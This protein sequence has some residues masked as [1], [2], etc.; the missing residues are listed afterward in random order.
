MIREF[1]TE[2]AESVCAVLNACWRP[3]SQI[4]ISPEGFR[5]V[6][7]SSPEWRNTHAFVGV[8]QE[9][10]NGFAAVVTAGNC[11][12]VAFLHVHPAS[13]GQGIGHGLLR[14]IE[15]TAAEHGCPVLS[16]GG[17]A[18]HSP[19]HGAKAGDADTDSFLRHRGCQPRFRQ[20]TRVLQLPTAIL[21]GR[22]SGYDRRGYD[23]QIVEAADVDYPAARRGVVALCHQCEAP[24][25]A[26][27]SCYVGAQVDKSNTYFAAAFHG[28]SLVGFVG[29]VPFRGVG[30]GYEA[31][32]Q[33]GPILV[34]PRHRNQGI[35]R[36]LLLTSLAA[37][38]DLGCDRA[39]L[40]GV[41][42]GPA[43]HLY[44]SIGFQTVVEWV[45][46]WKQR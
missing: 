8:Q 29:F 34:H 9:R 41:I 4:P 38:R 3:D 16:V 12:R 35:G 26:F 15:A 28:Q 24:A 42:D 33:W 17:Y 31:H 43:S 13:R 18:L 21:Q 19:F 39:V 32:P 37:M 46:Y 22:E 6:V 11:A 27:A 45:E 5:R 10:I 25:R 7:L 1:H 40:V 2:D 30:I 23:I 14:Q 36:S 44:G 20:A